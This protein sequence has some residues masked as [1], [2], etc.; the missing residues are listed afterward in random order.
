MAGRRL[1]GGGWGA[2]VRGAT[3]PGAITSQKLTKRVSG[4][5]ATDAARHV[6]LVFGNMKI[7]NGRLARS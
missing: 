3:F 1:Y 4:N 2:F 6:Q 5:Q 7:M